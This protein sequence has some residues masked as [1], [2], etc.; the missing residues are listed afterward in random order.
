ME[1]GK[2]ILD[3]SVV[4]EHLRNNES[5]T[6]TF[7]ASE[8]LFLPWV[9]LGELHHGA[10]KSEN[11][12]KKLAALDSFMKSVFMLWPTEDTCAAYGS[13]R[14]ELQKQGTP[15]PE[16]DVWIAATAKQ[17]GMTLYTQDQHFKQ[18]PGIDVLLHQGL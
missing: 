2:L 15:I 3:T 14:T 6:E 17:R 18:V 4:V 7:L 8:E 1:A 5:V 11:P 13:V 10:S 9:V 12:A 16:N